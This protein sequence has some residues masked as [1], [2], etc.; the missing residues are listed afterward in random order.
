MALWAVI[1]LGGSI[2][3]IAKTI[4]LD[5]QGNTILSIGVA[6]AFAIFSLAIVL[7]K[8]GAIKGFGYACWITVVFQGI[9]LFVAIDNIK[10]QGVMMS[11]LFFM[12][13]S[14]FFG[15]KALSAEITNAALYFQ[16]K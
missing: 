7:M 6:V 14:A 16:K 11:A 1:G 15:W 5:I 2:M 10:D 4:G 9:V 12:I 8:P 13:P 3:L